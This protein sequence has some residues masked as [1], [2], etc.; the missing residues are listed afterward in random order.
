MRDTL[1]LGSEEVAYSWYW[2]G[3]LTRS[4]AIDW[5]VT[6]VAEDWSLGSG[7]SFLA[8]SI[9]VGVDTILT[10]LD[11]DVDLGAAFGGFD[12]VLGDVVGAD[13]FCA[14]ALVDERVTR[15]VVVDVGAGL[16][17]L[18]FLGCMMVSD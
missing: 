3:F 14:W 8:L 4:E 7:S 12:S 10:G 16:A 6:L 9:A 17:A 15:L 13:V 11:F 1:A 2:I 5:V 18:R